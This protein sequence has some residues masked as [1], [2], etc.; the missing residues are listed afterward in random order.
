LDKFADVWGDKI[1]DGIYLLEAF[2]RICETNYI[3]YFLGF[4]T[5]LGSVRHKNPIPWDDDLDVLS[6]GKINWVQYR[7]QFSEYGIEIIRNHQWHKAYLKHNPRIG[8]HQHSW[9]FLDIFHY[10]PGIRYRV[11]H[12]VVTHRPEETDCLIS[13]EFCSGYYPIPSGYDNMLKRFYG[14]DH[15]EKHVSSG[16]D[17]RKERKIRDRETRIVDPSE[18]D[19]EFSEDILSIITGIRQS[20]TPKEMLEWTKATGPNTTQ[21]TK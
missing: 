21:T 8:R 7:D 3:K 5:L 16:W 19:Y 14:P 2:K 13:G 17:H 10:G 9:P 11:Q 1:V 12:M 20:K 6:F 15:L 18:N 4:G